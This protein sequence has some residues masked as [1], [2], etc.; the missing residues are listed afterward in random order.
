[1]PQ[2]M[3]IWLTDNNAEI[4]LTDSLKSS[5]AEVSRGE[6]QQPYSYPMGTNRG[7][8]HGHGL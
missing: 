3:E 5:C 6:I 1:M 2:F 7:I 4:E 8:Y